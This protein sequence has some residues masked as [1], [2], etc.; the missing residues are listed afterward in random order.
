MPLIAPLD[1]CGFL[2]V[3][4]GNVDSTGDPNLHWIKGAPQRLDLAAELSRLREGFLGESVLSEQH[5]IAATDDLVHRV[6][7]ARSHPE[8]RVRLLC[9]RRFDDDV[10]VLPILAAMRER[11]FR[12]EGLGDDFERF[13]EARVGLLQG[14]AEP[15]EFVVT[16]AL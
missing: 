14:Y 8:R 9:G 11:G 5:I 2:R 1:R 4:I 6:R 15:G 16:V 7:A 3:I 13:L 10:L 12:D